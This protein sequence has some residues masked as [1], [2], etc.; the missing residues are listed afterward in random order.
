MEM[1]SGLWGEEGTWAV[2]FALA[3]LLIGMA[4]ALLLR[5][6]R[7]WRRRPLPVQTMPKMWADFEEDTGKI[8]FADEDRTQPRLAVPASPSACNSAPPPPREDGQA[9]FDD[10]FS[11][12][13]VSAKFGALLAPEERKRE[14]AGPVPAARDSLQLIF[15]D[16]ISVARGPTLVL[17]RD[18]FFLTTPTP[19]PLGSRLAVR[20]FLAD[21]QTL[22][23]EEGEVI[24]SSPPGAEI[25]FRGLSAAGKAFLD[26]AR[27]RGGGGEA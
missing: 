18:G 9:V 7:R 2:R 17:R 13:E 16:A 21:G 11:E 10:D 22:L 14:A 20:F 25:R 19:P 1:W 23:E 24:N 15:P 8:R 27:N 4:A 5:P 26:Q 3:L 12:A 6:L